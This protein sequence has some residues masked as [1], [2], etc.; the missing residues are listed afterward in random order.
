[1]LEND[2]PVKSSLSPFHP[3]PAIG[4]KLERAK[5][6]VV[7][8]NLNDREDLEQSMKLHSLTKPLTPLRI[9]GYVRNNSVENFQ[10]QKPQ[11]L[12]RENTYEV[13]EP[14]YVTAA[15]VK[16]NDT[17]KKTRRS[18]ECNPGR[19]SNN[20]GPKDSPKTRFKNAALKVVKLSSMAE[21]GKLLCLREK[22]TYQI[23][24]NE[25][26]QTICR[27]DS[28]PETPSQKLNKLSEIFQNLEMNGQHR[29][30]LKKENSWF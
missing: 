11:Q 15:N 3:L 9:N 2:I 1:M 30:R 20:D 8:L 12:L 10:L 14:V 24:Q 22:Q 23:C 28:L 18:E 13:L 21:T 6:K 26:E 25:E 29:Q 17:P 7:I 4:Q 16:K 19:E 5:T 27:F